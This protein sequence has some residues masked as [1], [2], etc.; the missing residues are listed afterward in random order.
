VGTKDGRLGE[1]AASLILQQKGM[2]IVARNFR[3]SAGEVDIIADDNGVIVFVEV[4]ALLF[5][6][7]ESLEIAVNEKKQK[8]IIETAKCFLQNNREYSEAEV[9]FDVIFIGPDDK[10][11]RTFDHLANAF[12]E[13]V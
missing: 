8:R 1:D 11:E 5:Y 4:K 6:T 2:R 3:C 7:M 9:R 13:S 10:G 12:G